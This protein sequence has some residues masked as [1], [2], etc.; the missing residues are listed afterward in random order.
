A[1]AKQL[2]AAA[3]HAHDIS[4]ELWCGLEPPFPQVAQSIQAYLTAVGIHVT[5]VQRENN[6]LR[7]AARNGKTD[8]VLKDWYADYIDAENFL[9]PLLASANVGQGGNVSFYSN[10]QFDHLIASAR[11]ESNENV[12]TREY[13]QADS[14][15]FADAPMLFLVFYNELYAVQPWLKGFQ[16]PVIFNAQR[17]TDVE[18]AH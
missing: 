18:I 6:A 2:L 11:A 17:W 15:A 5:I 12:R 3:G 1:R 14:I 9:Y 13:K 10:P 4:L 16:P 7:E 8:I